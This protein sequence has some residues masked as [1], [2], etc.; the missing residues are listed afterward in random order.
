M[1]SPRRGG[2]DAHAHR[3]RGH[4]G[5]RSGTGED[6]SGVLG[7]SWTA[8]ATIAEGTTSRLPI[9]TARPTLNVADDGL[10]R[11][12]SGCNSGRTTV[13][14]DGDTLSFASTRVTRGNCDGPAGLTEQLVLSVLDGP[15]DHAELHEKVLIVTKGDEGLVFQLR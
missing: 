3:R 14:V 4:V 15:A 12:F 1:E 2:I 13:Q 11:L 9:R 5:A 6:L 8:V 7:R 10:A